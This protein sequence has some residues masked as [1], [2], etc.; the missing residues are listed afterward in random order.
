MSLLYRFMLSRII[1]TISKGVVFIMSPFLEDRLYNRSSYLR[2]NQASTVDL[3]LC[4]YS[5]TVWR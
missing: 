1:K 4:S 2:Y 3:Y 5:L